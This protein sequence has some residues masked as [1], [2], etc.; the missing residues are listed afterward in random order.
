MDFVSR[1]QFSWDFA[2]HLLSSMWTTCLTVDHQYQYPRI[3]PAITY[4]DLTSLL[5]CRI[6]PIGISYHFS[7]STSLWSLFLFCS[8][9]TCFLSIVASFSFKFQISPCIISIVNLVSYIYVSVKILFDLCVL[10][11]VIVSPCNTGP[12]VLNQPD[13]VSI[14][15]H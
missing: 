7:P 15:S 2:S 5:S 11:F 6:N 4:L 13:L 9:F 3:S 14:F 8:Y 1:Y 10:N 12:L